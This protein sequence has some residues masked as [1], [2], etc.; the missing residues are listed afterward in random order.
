VERSS[1]TPTRPRE[2][3]EPLLYS[4]GHSTQPF[5]ALVKLLRQHEIQVVADVRTAPFSRFNPQ[6]NRRDLQ[7]GLREAGI[8][9]VFLGKELGGRPDDEEFYDPDDHVLYGRM[10]ATP[11]FRAGIERLLDGAS[12]YRVAMMCSEED[13]AECH[14]FL[15][16]TR[17]LHSEGVEV[18]HIRADGTSQ[19]TEDVR[20]YDDWSA[21]G[22]EQ[23]SLFDE[24][25]RSPW[26]ST[27]SVSQRRRPQSSSSR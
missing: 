9:Y 7:L 25:A 12:Q 19:R 27:R 11:R 14:R 5:E 23:R 20:T 13:P 4:I 1:V 3:S 6:F 18:R 16:I 24:S 15:L 8:E 26:R 21:G 22:H 2:Q 17:V 10:A